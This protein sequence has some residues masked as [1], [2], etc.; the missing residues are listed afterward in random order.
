MTALQPAPRSADPVDGTR[1]RILLAATELFAE[2]G[3]HNTGMAQLEER[4]RV[5]RGALYHHI[6]S[7]EALL[8]DIVRAQLEVVTAEVEAV[9]ATTPD[10]RARVRRMAVATLRNFA[11]HHL[12]WRVHA[13]DFTA[14]TGD[15]L[16]SV[17]DL[18]RRHEALWQGVIAE[19]MGGP[20]PPPQRVSVAAKGVLGMLNYTHV[21]MVA[22]GPMRPEAIADLYCDL[23]LRGLG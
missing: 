3:Y 17:L 11:D 15:H 23:I 9:I 18:R 5:R 19:A 14:L 12:E 1:A 6:G 4:A 10:L 16:T 8:Y 13:R 7:K 21:W 2:H 22:D 20:A